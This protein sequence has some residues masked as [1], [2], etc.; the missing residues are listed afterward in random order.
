M[1]IDKLKQEYDIQDIPPENPYKPILFGLFWLFLIFGILAGWAAYAP[2]STSITANGEVSADI[3]KKVVQSLEGGVIKKIY[4]DNGDKVKK[5]QLL[6]K[7]DDEEIKAKLHSLNEK[8]QNLLAKFARLKAQKLNRSKIDFPSDLKEEKK[9]EQIKVFNLMKRN[10]QSK[11]EIKQEKIKQLQE[12]IKGYKELIKSLKSQLSILRRDFNTKNRL[13]KQKL[14][15]KDKV[16]D[17]ALKIQNTQGEIN[18]KRAQILSA[19][20]QIQAIKKEIVVEKKSFQQNVLKDYLDT[21]SRLAD[22]KADIIT[23]KTKL[24]R[25]EIKAP[26]DGIVFGLDTHTVGA[27]IEPRK[28]ILEIVPL[29]TKLLLDVKIDTPNISKIKNGMTATVIFPSFDNKKIDKLEGKVIYISADAI[30]DPREKKTYYKVKIELTPESMDKIKEFNYKLIPG[31]P[32]SAMINTG[33]KTL[34][35]Y[36]IKPLKELLLKSFNEE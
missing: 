34:L 29:G 30:K 24:E 27:V 28:T 5:H 35:E 32:V 22:I 33:E 36:L 6:I 25:T 9:L 3:N 21:K 7:L 13:Y 23:Y 10:L 20:K 16:N 31:M 14:I 4:V 11:I 19:K 15:N 8:Y 2:L 17:L 12:Q 26:I 18:Q 1:E